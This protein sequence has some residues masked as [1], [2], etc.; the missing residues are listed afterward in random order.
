MLKDNLFMW[1]NGKREFL[2]KILIEVNKSK[3]FQQ[4]ILI[5]DWT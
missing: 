4:E 3:D 5:P 2:W 1:V